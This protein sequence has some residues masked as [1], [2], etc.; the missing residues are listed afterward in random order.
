MI[1]TLTSTPIDQENI[2]SLELIKSYLYLDVTDTSE[3][4]L[5]E[6]LRSQV[7]SF[8][9]IYTSRILGSSDFDLDLQV[10]IND[11]IRIAKTPTTEITSVKQKDSDGN[12][13]DIDYSYN[14]GDR[15]YV[16]IDSYDTSIDY[17][18]SFTSGYAIAN[19]PQILQGAM[20]SHIAY[21]YENRGDCCEANTPLE[22]LQKYST[23]K[24]P[25]I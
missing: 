3:D 20:L 23:F 11:I 7:I 12:Y 15:P 21:L 19:I 24:V 9:E 13:Q 17:K 6:F 2:L 22:I 14:L 16:T 18:V 25:V 10:R 1:Y 5:L 8:C 4:T